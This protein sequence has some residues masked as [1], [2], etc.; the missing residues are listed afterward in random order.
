MN[1]EQIQTPLD[2]WRKAILSE[3]NHPPHKSMIECIEKYN[4]LINN[5][6]IL[7]DASMVN[8]RYLI[9]EKGVGH[10]VDVDSSPVL[11][12]EVYFDKNDERLERHVETFDTYKF[13][14]AT[15]DF[16]YGK[17]ISFNKRDKNEDVLKGV[18]HA[19]TN[20]GIFL[21]VWL[22]KN[23]YV[24]KAEF[25]YDENEIREMYENANLEIKEF[26]HNGPK[27]GN[28][29]DGT[30]RIFEDYRVIACKQKSIN[31]TK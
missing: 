7:G 26:V 2:I 25:W 11:L 29:L 30:V 24:G 15:F 4:L 13:P 9:E 23:S 8:A 14:E 10:V 5:A 3:R 28:C 18:T 27:E 6:L 12:D 16:I 22:G 1:L 21:A 31:H 19:L 20:N 17:S